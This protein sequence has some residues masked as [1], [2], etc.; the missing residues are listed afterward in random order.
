MVPVDGC[1]E[2]GD[3]GR[4][5]SVG[6]VD[7][8]FE[9]LEQQAQRFAFCPETTSPGLR[10][11]MCAMLQADMPTAVGRLVQAGG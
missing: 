9:D 4:E 7:E 8:A 1:L 3:G 5:P 11:D 2:Q 10:T 6:R